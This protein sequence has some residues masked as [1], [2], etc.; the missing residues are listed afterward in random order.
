MREQANSDFLDRLPVFYNHKEQRKATTIANF[1]RML[2]FPLDD[3]GDGD[4]ED[5]QVFLCLYCVC[6]GA[7]RYMLK[8]KFHI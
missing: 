1:W 8:I 2:F 6:S 5:T 7:H 4:Y 3:D